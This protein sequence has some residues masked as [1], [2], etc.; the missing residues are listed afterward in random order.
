MTFSKGNIVEYGPHVL[1]RHVLSNCILS[2]G[3]TT[4]VR[5]SQPCSRIRSMAC[6]QAATTSGEASSNSWRY[7]PTRRPF[8]GMTTSAAAGLS[9]NSCAGTASG[10]GRGAAFSMP[11]WQLNLWQFYASLTEEKGRGRWPQG[12]QPEG[13]LCTIM[14]SRMHEGRPLLRGQEER[15]WLGHL[16]TLGASGHLRWR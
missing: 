13:L 14:Q 12:L 9:S 1:H 16:G 4:D 8:S 3:E 11:A 6:L 10:A 15:E 2:G 7:T 5:T